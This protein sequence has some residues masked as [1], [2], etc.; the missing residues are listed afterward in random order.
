MHTYPQNADLKHFRS[1]TSLQRYRVLNFF[2]CLPKSG[3]VVYLYEI[4]HIMNNTRLDAESF[5][6]LLFPV[7][8]PKSSNVFGGVI[9]VIFFICFAIFDFRFHFRFRI[10]A[11]PDFLGFQKIYDMK[12][13]PLSHCIS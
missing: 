8:I 4:I 9:R 7:S 1:F 6:R 2:G 12:R 3:D 5:C 13:T 11:P 10:Q